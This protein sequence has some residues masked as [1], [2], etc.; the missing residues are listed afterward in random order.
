MCSG[1]SI[2]GTAFV[3][4]TVV[5]MCGGLM[6][7]MLH[8]FF[9]SMELSGMGSRSGGVGMAGGKTPTE[10]LSFHPFCGGVHG[11]GFLTT[12]VFLLPTGAVPGRVPD[13]VVGRF[14]GADVDGRWSFAMYADRQA[15]AEW[16]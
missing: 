5:I 2:T 4:L 14:P 16:R 11:L 7:F 6:S 9:R 3:G 1:M 15:T 13:E 8:E 12:F 10:Y